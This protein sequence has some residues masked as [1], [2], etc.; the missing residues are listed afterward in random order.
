MPIGAGI[1]A[2]GSIGSALIGGNAA[3][4]AAQEQE[5]AAQQAEQTQLQMYNQTR[6]DLSPYRTTGGSALSSIADM[7][8]LAGGTGANAGSTGSGVQNFSA[9]TNSP[10]YQFALQQGGQAVDESA[11]SKGQTLSGA[12]QMAQ[13][14]F[15]QGL[16]SQQFNQ[17]YANLSGLAG[18]GES[19]SAQQANANQSTGNSLASLQ[20]SAGTSA[21]SGTVGAANA[22][23]GG[24]NSGASS[25]GLYS[26]LN[27][28]G[29]ANSASSYG[30]LSSLINPNITPVGGYG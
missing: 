22:L 5:Q 2:I 18:L 19:A 15:G 3:Q 27:N 16:A 11:A 26:L 7:Y 29:G 25:L 9:F 21:A 1:G 17:Y 4:T 10:N 20:T 13:L 30:G 6:S 23:T 12:N 14:S 28:G 24:I 8:G